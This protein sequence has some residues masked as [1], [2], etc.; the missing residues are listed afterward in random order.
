MNALHHIPEEITA[1]R[2]DLTG[3]V[4][5]GALP[6]SRARLLP[7]AM[8]KL[9]SRHPGIKIVTNESGFTALIAE[10]RAGDIDFIIGALRNEKM[11]LDIHS[12]IL[13]E[14]ELILLA[15]PNHPLSD[16]RVKKPRT[17]RYSMGFTPKSRPITPPAGSRI[18]Q[19]GTRIAPAS[20]R[21]R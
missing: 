20:S 6:L 3:S 11:L 21:K 13:F 12:E 14:E 16:R 4:R 5:V 1:H 8:I 17:K 15:R 10:L 7:Q 9:I 19:N 18:L 2:G